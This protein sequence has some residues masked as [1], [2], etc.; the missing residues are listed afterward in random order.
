MNLAEAFHLLA[1]S[2]C[3]LSATPAGEIAVTVPDGSAVPAAVLDVLRYHRHELVAAMAAPASP[4]VA[5]LR[6]Y[7]ATKGI[8]G[9]SADLVERAARVFAVSHDRIVVGSDREE[10]PPARCD[11]GVPFATLAD[12]QW[13]MP[14]GGTKMIARGALGLLIP[15]VRTIADRFQ[16]HGVEAILDSIARRKLPRHIPAWL[17]GQARVIEASLIEF[18]HVVAPRGMNLT[19]WRPAEPGSPGK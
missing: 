6:D 17:D 18:E 7:L 14:G 11:P 10:P 3:R 1:T 12:T 4:A 19:P 9:S 2:G 13:A 15:Q 16:R 5:D 8:T